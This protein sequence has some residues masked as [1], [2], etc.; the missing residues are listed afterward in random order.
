MTFPLSGFIRIGIAI[1]VCHD[2]ILPIVCPWSYYTLRPLSQKKAGVCPRD[3]RGP[4]VLI[5][6][7][8]DIAYS[9]DAC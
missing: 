2:Q 7:H 8:I 1:D 9:D 5:T 4:I 6:E 3:L